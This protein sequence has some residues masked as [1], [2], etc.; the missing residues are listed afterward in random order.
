MRVSSWVV[1]LAFDAALRGQSLSACFLCIRIGCC[2]GSCMAG[3]GMPVVAGGF[4]LM[5]LGNQ[6]V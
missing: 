2:F 1:V 3:L 4:G 5:R 6:D